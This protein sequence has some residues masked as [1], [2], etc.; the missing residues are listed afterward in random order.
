MWLKVFPY[1][2]QT[3]PQSQAEQNKFLDYGEER[4]NYCQSY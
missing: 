2:E 1:R 4:A 3:T